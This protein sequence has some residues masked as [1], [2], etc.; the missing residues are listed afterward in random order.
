MF[1]FST[2]IRPHPFVQVLWGRWDW[3]NNQIYRLVCRNHWSMGHCYQQVP[4]NGW[5]LSP[6]QRINTPS[7][8]G[9]LPFHDGFH[10][11]VTSESSDHETSDAFAKAKARIP[12]ALHLGLL[13]RAEATR[14]LPD[15]ESY[16]E[17]PRTCL[18]RNHRSL[19]SE[20]SRSY[21]EASITRGRGNNGFRITLFRQRS[22][23]QFWPVQRCQCHRYAHP[24]HTLASLCASHLVSEE[25]GG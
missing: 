20:S 22:S 8:A 12:V 5:F 2:Q 23:P 4:R 6:P 25:A 10:G 9:N 19:Q 21:L 11:P 15:M 13:R 7:H 14:L 17:V 18:R 16:L 1:F 24:A 3:T